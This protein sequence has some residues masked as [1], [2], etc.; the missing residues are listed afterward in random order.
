M[1]S[2]KLILSS[3]TFKAD[4]ELGTG[5]N[6]RQISIVEDRITD[7]VLFPGASIALQGRIN[8]LLKET[9]AEATAILAQAVAEVKTDLGFVLAHYAAETPQDDAELA[10]SRDGTLG[11]IL[12][13]LR[14]LKARVEDVRETAAR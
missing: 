4:A 12:E 8:A 11:E 2:S 3:K 9:K 1:V 5:K 6:K 14:I 13:R 10:A 7:G